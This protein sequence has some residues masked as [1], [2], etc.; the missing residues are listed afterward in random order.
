MSEKSNQ[1]LPFVPEW[2]ARR[3]DNWIEKKHHNTHSFFN[4]SRHNIYILPSKAGW[5]F[6]LTLI[7]ILSGAINYNNNMAYLLCFFLA[8]LGF[9]AMLQTHQNISGIIIKSAHSPAVYCGREIEFNFDVST[10]TSHHHFSIHI[11]NNKEVLSVSNALNPKFTVT[12]TAKKRGR[13]NPSRFKVCSEFPL[14]LFHAWTQVNINNSVI[15]YPK[16]VTHSVINSDFS[17]GNKQTR[18]AIGDDE[19]TGIRNYI[20]GDNPKKMAWKTIA[21]TNIL[22]TKEFH[23]ESGDYLIFD[24]KQLSDITN[25]EE[26]LSILCG[27]I[28]NTHNQKTIYGLR[29]PK[30]VIGPSHGENHLHKCLSQLALFKT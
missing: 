23:T 8:S 20:K 11:E 19:Y 13:Q 28:I 18:K 27:L 30:K 29:L 15:I 2:L 16:P 21:K 14:G 22:Y 17:S 26:K 4:I 6:I 9:I 5:L 12:D 7:A 10:N 24:Y 3:I 1:N 25:I